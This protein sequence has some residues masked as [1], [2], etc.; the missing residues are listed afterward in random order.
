MFTT[1]LKNYKKALNNYLPG[2]ITGAS[3]DD[4]SGITSYSVVGATTGY[5]Q[6]WLMFLATPFLIVVQGVCAK[7]GDVLKMGLGKA[8]KNHYGFK[9]SLFASIILLLANVATISADFV[10]MAAVLNMLFPA[11]PVSMFLPILVLLLWYLVV[12]RSYGLIKNIFFILA[13]TLGVYLIAGFLAKPDWGLVLKNTFIPQIENSIVFY[14]AAL[15]LLG[16]TI[17]PYVFYWQTS[18]EVED[19]RSVFQG[20]QA[21]KYVIPGMVYS[22]IISFFVILATATVLFKNGIY[23]IQTPREIAESLKPL[24]GDFS[25]WLFSVGIIGSGLLAIPVL[26]ASSSYA[27]A[28][29]FGWREGLNQKI[30][31][32]R[33]FYAFLTLIFLISLLI[34]FSPISPIKTLFYSQVLNGLLAPFLLILILMIS[35]SEKIMSKYRNGFLTNTIMSFTITVMLV[36]SFAFFWN[37]LGF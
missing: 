23:D 21:F 29:T 17:T 26:A 13:S 6:L 32:A 35:A 34:V 18:E 5:A 8:I 15:A 30:D 22:N 9:L 37:L 27:M 7:I 33:G 19:K 3:D 4:V 16:T 12:F 31:H 25:V 28:E 2:I 36:T 20:K 11:V 1:R 14:A 24:A 10:G